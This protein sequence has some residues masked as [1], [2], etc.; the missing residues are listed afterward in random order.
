MQII[1][2]CLSFMVHLNKLPGFKHGEIIPTVDGMKGIYTD[3]ANGQKYEVVVRPIEDNLK[4]RLCGEMRAAQEIIQG[5]GDCQ[6]CAL[7]RVEP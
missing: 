1:T 3:E 2:H 4:C 6:F 5:A 7:Q